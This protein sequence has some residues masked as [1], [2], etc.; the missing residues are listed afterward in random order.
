MILKVLA[1][2]TILVLAF[3]V[4]IGLNVFQRATVLG[5]PTP[6]YFQLPMMQH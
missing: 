6:H 2:S 3:S 4:G 1:G 5:A